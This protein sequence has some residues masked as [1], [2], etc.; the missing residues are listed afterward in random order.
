MKDAYIRGII[1]GLIAGTLKD[2]PDVILDLTFKVKA[3]MCLDYAGYIGFNRIPHTFMEYLFAYGLE[4]VFSAGLGVIF[5]LLSP[6]IPSK[7]YLIKGMMFGG[8][9][10][11]VLTSMVRMIKITKLMTTDLVTPF[12]TLLFSIGYGLV[13]AYIDHYLENSSWKRKAF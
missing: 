2:I 3:L 10:W 6:K 4:V 12:L 5:S 13:V 9:I 7:H 11:Y 1:A 8:F